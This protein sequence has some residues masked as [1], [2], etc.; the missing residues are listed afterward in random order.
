M[1]GRTEDE[2]CMRRVGL[3][4]VALVCEAGAEFAARARGEVMA[5]S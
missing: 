2:I 3:D 1:L 5:R 4:E